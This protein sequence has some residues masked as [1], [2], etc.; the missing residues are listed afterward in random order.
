[1]EDHRS[2]PQSTPAVIPAPR[3]AAAPARRR[4]GTFPAII[5]LL[6]LAVAGYAAWRVESGQHGAS[7]RNDE[8]L[9]LLQQQ[10]DEGSRDEGRLRHDVDALR[11][12]L[13]DAETVN[14]GI[15]EEMLSLAERN[16]HLDDAIANVAEQRLTGRDALA[17]NEAEFLLLI[18]EERYA[19]FGDA[20][21]AV[22]AFR[23]ADNALAASEDPVFAS[24]RLTIGAEIQALTEARA[25]DPA[26]TL[27]SLGQLRDA[28]AGWP[29]TAPLASGDNATKS[30][31]QRI[32]A[33]FIQIRREG[34]A[35][36]TRDP[37]LLRSLLAIDLQTAAATWLAR[38]EA[39]YRAALA[40][41]RTTIASGFDA[42]AEPV[43]AAL[44]DVDRLA[45]L[46]MAAALPVLGTALQE[47]RNLRAN[48]TL[49]RQGAEATPAPAA[50]EAGNTT[51]QP[52]SGP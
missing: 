23:L 13:R 35:T 34:D 50:P 18:G 6:A 4:G 48:R 16:R 45:A 2:E 51:D 26:V 21:A 46:P 5:A 43:R 41:A 24:V 39:G 7:A 25:V 17:L 9:S 12:R 22:S 27:A 15:R 33:S 1:M 29:L 32:F 36:A 28:A 11:T 3:P 52:G 44:A 19:L 49:S 30:R 40:R 37:V 47:L 31:F 10:I 38:D 14:K 8:K 20:A 42:G